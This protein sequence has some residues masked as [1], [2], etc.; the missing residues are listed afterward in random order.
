[1]QVTGIIDKTGLTPWMSAGHDDVPYN[2]GD[3][4]NLLMRSYLFI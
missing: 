2:T 3:Y 1:M 4:R